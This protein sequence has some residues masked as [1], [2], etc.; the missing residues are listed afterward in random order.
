MLIKEKGQ[1]LL[2]FLLCIRHDIWNSL[3]DIY[4]YHNKK[5]SS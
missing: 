1:T 3:T 5:K 4:S 2:I